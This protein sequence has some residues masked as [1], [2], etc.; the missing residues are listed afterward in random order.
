[1]GWEVVRRGMSRA[2]LQQDED[3]TAD[4]ERAV[5][6]VDAVHLH[7]QLRCASG[8]QSSFGLARLAASPNPRLSGTR[9]SNFKTS[10]RHPLRPPHAVDSHRRATALLISLLGRLLAALDA[11]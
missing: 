7:R 11:T 3:K 1:M 2:K 5:V 8:A 6:N 4:R 10:S 9:W